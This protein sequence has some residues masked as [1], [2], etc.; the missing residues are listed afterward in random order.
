[1]RVYDLEK[2]AEPFDKMGCPISVY[3]KKDIH[4]ADC[5]SSSVLS[6]FEGKKFPIPVGW[7]DMLTDLYK[8]YLSL[9]PVEKRQSNHDAKAYRLEENNTIK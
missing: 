3:R 6:D 5:F 7:N 8:D 1:M 4:K 9:P 2:N